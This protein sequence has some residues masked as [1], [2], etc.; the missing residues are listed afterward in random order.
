MKDQQAIKK[1]QLL[2]TMQPAKHTLNSIKEG[3]YY[4]VQ[5]ENKAQTNLGIQ[6]RFSNISTFLKTY[7]VAYYAGAIAFLL[8][9]FLSASVLLFP[10]QTHTALLYGKLALAQ[11]QYEKAR[12]ALNDTKTKFADNKTTQVNTNELVYSLAL[13]NTQLNAL[14]LKGEKGKYT[15][16]ECHNIYQ[17][18]LSYLEN[19]EKN[20]QSNNSMLKSQINSYEEQAEKKLHMYKSL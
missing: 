15:A 10:N 6:D 11:N 1:L 2:K 17:E 12:I 19:K 18:Y 16:E 8:V 5:S 14:R 3:V 4:Q 20:M 9:I 13:T 7:G